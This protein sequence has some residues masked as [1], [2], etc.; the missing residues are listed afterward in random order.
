L[1]SDRLGLVSNTVGRALA[2]VLAALTLYLVVLALIDENILRLGAIAL[3]CLI[4]LFIEP[5]AVK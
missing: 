5:L 3:S 1:A 4:V 2:L